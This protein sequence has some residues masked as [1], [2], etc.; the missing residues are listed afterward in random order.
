MDRSW[1]FL[2]F[3]VV[4]LFFLIVI[5]PWCAH[6]AGLLAPFLFDVCLRMQRLKHLITMLIEICNQVIG[7][8]C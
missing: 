3:W 2:A 7:R 8:L 1:L 6:F 5:G 4:V